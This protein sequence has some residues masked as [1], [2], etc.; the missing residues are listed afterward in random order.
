MLVFYLKPLF[1][2]CYEECLNCSTNNMM[3]KNKK[4][5]KPKNWK[6]S[7]SVSFCLWFLLLKYQPQPNKSL[8][9]FK[10]CSTLC[11]AILLLKTMITDITERDMWGYL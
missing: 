1:G 9:A 7:V 5:K 8:N 2:C 10:H 3:M 6:C 4:K 11:I